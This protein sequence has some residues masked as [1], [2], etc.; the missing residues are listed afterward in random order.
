MSEEQ[1]QD[2]QRLPDGSL[3]IPSWFLK[4]CSAALVV[5]LFCIGGAIPWAVNVERSLSNISNK[6]DVQVE[7][8]TIHQQELQRKLDDHEA[9]MRIL[10]QELRKQSP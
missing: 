9:R 2:N 8:S 5:I 1:T 3:V 10:E 6:V 4:V 7:I